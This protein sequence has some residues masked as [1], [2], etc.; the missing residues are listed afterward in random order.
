MATAIQKQSVWQYYWASLNN[1]PTSVL[2][3]C[4][5]LLV[6][7]LDL[8]LT[9]LAVNIGLVE[10]NPFVNGMLSSPVKLLMAKFFIPLLIVWLV[11]GKLLIPG[12]LLLLVIIAWY[13]QELLFFVL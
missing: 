13:I 2:L 3:K 7:L 11:P 8:G 1:N 6:Q 10:L 9:L 12:I 5:Y 4:A